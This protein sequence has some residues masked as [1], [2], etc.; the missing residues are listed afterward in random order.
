MTALHIIGGIY[1]ERCVWPPWNQ[2][3]GSGGRAAAAVSGH[4]DEIVLSGYATPN[5]QRLFEPLAR[6][7]K[8]EF[9]PTESDQE[10]SFDYVHSLSSPVIAP[11][12]PIIKQEPLIDVSADVV[13]R[14]GMLEGSARVKAKRC[15][16]DPQSAFRPEPF[17]YNG[18]SAETLAIVGNRKEVVALAG[19]GNDPVAAAKSLLTTR[20]QVVVI[21]G[22]VG[23]AD[24]VDAD[25]ITHVPAYQTNNIFKVGS[26]D[27][28][29][30]VFAAH[31]GVLNKAARECAFMA[32]RAVAEYVEHMALPI[33]LP[34]TLT[35]LPAARSNV[36]L[37]Y[38]AG[39]FF[40]L[41]QRWLVDEAR[42]CLLELGMKVFSP[43]HDIGA[44]PAEQVA[45]ADLEALDR[46]DVVFALLDGMDS[47]TLFEVGWA[48]HRGIPVY[49][50]AQSSTAEDLKMVEGSGC[51]VFE[52]FATALHHAAWRT[53]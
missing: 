21:K 31:W 33:P 41:G 34:D 44:G 51:H 48:R 43:I 39:P 5:M 40:N 47:G 38:L 24:V 49:C 52:D 13:L 12:P 45:P 29:A 2:V 15:V 6:L 30:A 42:R 1:R 26:G 4:V 11:A 10:I 7:E 20:T 37:V 22:G 17:E 35:P 25:G 23:G 14:F 53:S 18:S 50:L 28:F 46:A 16:Y 32:S 27:V 8:I 9:R 36:G 19:G 3:W